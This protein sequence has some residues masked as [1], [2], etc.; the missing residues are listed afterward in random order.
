MLLIKKINRLAQ[1]TDCNKTFHFVWDEAGNSVKIDRKGAFI[2]N[3]AYPDYRK[4]FWESIE[5][6]NKH[7]TANLRYTNSSGFHS[8]SV[9]QV[10]VL[11]KNITWNFGFSS[12]LM[13]TDLVYQIDNEKINLTG[14]NKVF[15]RN[16]KRKFVQ[17]FKRWSLPVD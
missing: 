9:I 4:T 14:K 7:T 8:D 12:A 11:I 5:E 16:K 17:I 3:S 13:E 1:E 6:L 10:K 15:G 2:G